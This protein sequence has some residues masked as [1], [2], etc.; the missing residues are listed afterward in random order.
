MVRIIEDYIDHEKLSAKHGDL[1]FE[2]TMQVEMSDGLEQ[3]RSMVD[4][5]SDNDDE[6]DED[7]YDDDDEMDDITSGELDAEYDDYDDDD[8]DSY[9]EIDAE[10]DAAELERQG[11]KV[12]YIKQGERLEGPEALEEVSKDARQARRQEEEDDQEVIEMVSRQHD[13]YKYFSSEVVS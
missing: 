6:D 1:V 4:S 2:D 9:D 11:L 8:D 13:Q 10:I 7:D 12:S 3:V 5:L